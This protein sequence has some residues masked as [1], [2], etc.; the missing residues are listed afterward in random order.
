MLR[1]THLILVAIAIAGLVTFLLLSSRKI[2]TV[3]ITQH[4]SRVPITEVKV[5]K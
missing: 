2:P 4:F 3:G 1:L 5:L